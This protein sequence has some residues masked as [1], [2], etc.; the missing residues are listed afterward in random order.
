MVKKKPQLADYL[1]DTSTT[2]PNPI[3]E[4]NLVTT[5]R[6]FWQF[7][8][9]Y[10][11]A[12]FLGITFSFIGSGIDAFLIA[13]LKHIVDAEAGVLSKKVLL[14]FALLLVFLMV[15]RSL[16]QFGVGYLFS[17]AQTKL[18][19]SVMNK[20]FRHI[21]LMPQTFF[22][23]H[24]SSK[25][26]SKIQNEVGQMLGATGSSLLSISR[27]G[28]TVLSF[29]VVMFVTNW[30]LSSAVILLIPLIYLVLKLVS[31]T[32][33]KLTQGQLKAS[34]VQ[35][36]LLNEMVKGH[37]IVNLYNAQD[38]ET[39]RF[40]K[41]AEGIRKR[42]TKGTIAINLG[43]SLVQLVASILLVM[44][45]VLAAYASQLNLPPITPGD[46][47]V[48][49]TSM[50]SLLKPVRN[51]SNI[52]TSFVV[53]LTA[54][55]SV[56]GILALD[57]EED[58]GTLTEK[59]VNFRG[60][61][62]YEDVDFAYPTR[63]TEMILK[64]FN[65]EIKSGKTFAFV[66]KS[67]GGKSTIVSLLTRAYNVEQGMITIDG[68]NIRDIKLASLRDN[69]SV[70]SQNV[71]LFDDTIYN[72]IIYCDQDKYT[73]EQVEEAA[74]LAY[75]TNFA[76]D[77][78]EGLD[79]KIGSDGNRLSGGQKQRVAIARAL[80]RNNPILILDEAT[81]ALD[82][83][84]EF[85]IQ[86]SLEELQKGK[87]VLTIAHRLSTIENADQICVI[88]DGKVVEQGTHQ[89]LI[90]N[91]TGEYYKLYTRDFEQQNSQIE[92]ITP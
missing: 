55:K 47:I 11:W 35:T 56:M 57:T 91:H 87:T 82:N 29:L 12:L 13:Q 73:K 62:R 42:S 81:S 8:K 92:I 40:Y 68:H 22:D 31:K 63:P 59:E 78:P 23:V 85:F 41:T 10:Q 66:G 46:F 2:N 21:S 65:L 33:R 19:V 43:H 20:V 76:E 36:Q 54:G 90:Q 18:S 24:G 17:W 49:F 80:L 84:S 45:I 74:R 48:I 1:A 15:I 50:F 26:I 5:F 71:H 72:N 44:V 88:I 75:V 14:G 77:F 27:D 32:I 51:L 69:I 64:D 89:E 28:S 37:Q 53:S 52:Y 86:K 34:E 25:I 83:E 4:T 70:V 38:F 58:K 60:T 61:I 30:L 67:G 7:V 6:L 3:L 39:E 16:L 9:P 79:T